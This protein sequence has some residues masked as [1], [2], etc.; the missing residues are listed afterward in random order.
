MLTFIFFIIH[1]WIEKAIEKDAGRSTVRTTE[2]QNN[3][4]QKKS[5][6]GKFSYP[7]NIYL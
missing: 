1:P 7:K 3:A 4:K 2:P 5:Y 6:I